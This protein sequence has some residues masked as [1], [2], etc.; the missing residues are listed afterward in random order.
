MDGLK[1]IALIKSAKFDFNEIDLDGNNLFIGANGAGKTT[2]LRAILYFYTADA[3]SLGINSTKKISFNDYYFE[4][5][6]SY[7]IYMYKKDDQYILTIIYKD[8]NIKFRL[9]LFMKFQ[10]SKIYL[11]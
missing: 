6:H 4:Y 5:Q 9:C 7:L 11:S 3:R 8:S 2:L 1:K 10:I